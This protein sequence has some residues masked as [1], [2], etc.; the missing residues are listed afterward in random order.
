[1]CVAS[2]VYLFCFVLF[3]LVNFC[4]EKFQQYLKLFFPT[5]TTLKVYINFTLILITFWLTVWGYWKNFSLKNFNRTT[6]TKQSDLLPER[7]K[8]T[9][10]LCIEKKNIYFPYFVKCTKKNPYCTLL[11]LF[12]FNKESR[13]SDTE[14][15]TILLPFSI[16]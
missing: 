10:L 11:T 14:N 9:R 12:F 3:W 5:P 1:M 2:V 4:R 7:R 8:H 13:C 16:V 15:T 6:T